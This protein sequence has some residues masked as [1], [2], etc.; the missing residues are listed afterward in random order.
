MKT[1]VWYLL[2]AVI[3]LPFFVLGFLGG[4]ALSGLLAGYRV[5]MSMYVN[6]EDES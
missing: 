2:T 3:G 4:Y 1:A 6:D 5:F